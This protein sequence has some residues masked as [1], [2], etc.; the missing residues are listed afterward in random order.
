MTEPKTR[1]YP[2][3]SQR[4]GK[5]CDRSGTCRCRW[6]YV[7]E[8][9]L[10]GRRVQ[11]T[12]AGFTSARE[13]AKARAAAI[14]ELQGNPVAKKGQTVGPYLAAWL[15]RKE[16]TGSLRASTA[17]SYRG[18][19]DGYLSP[20]LGRVKLSDLNVGHLDHLR[21]ELR[22]QRPDM[23]AATTTR[24]FATLRSAL[25]DAYRRGEISD[26]PTRRMERIKTTRPRV[27][28]WQPAE[29]G[30][31]LD[32]AYA[33]GERLAPI[34]EA[35]A[36][37]GL[38][39]GEVLGLRWIDVDLDRSRLV[40]AQQAVAIGKELV[41]GA[42]KTTAGEHRVVDL[43]A[44]TVEL[45]RSWRLRQDAERAEWGDSWQ[46]FGLVWTWQDGRP[47]APDDL[48]RRFPRLIKR[49]NDE[50]R[51]RL[52]SAD[53]DELARL[54][55]QDPERMARI[56]SSDA[57]A[58]GALPLLHFHSLRHLQASLMLAAGAPLALVS[59]R[60]GHSSIT[61][62]SDTY[63]HLLDGVGAQAATAAAALI[64][65]RSPAVP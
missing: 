58:G 1:R 20:I 30:R 17:A 42:P 10:A 56:R 5:G 62:T 16:S 45:L 13:A 25:R 40:V 44:G 15:T 28:V 41:L 61:L 33:A 64:P 9:T 7:A 14:V 36:T 22:R 39:R 12:K 65:R 60:L 29:L 57:L 11:A 51:I 43:D 55:A 4:H 24:V 23:S 8:T 52:L 59:K 48:T 2:G 53:S 3:V 19:V 46:D 27:E 32:W 18:H 38:R 49:F 50:R 37:T 26:D 63:S 54:E 47:L 21:D 6:S 34:I 35:T 31:F